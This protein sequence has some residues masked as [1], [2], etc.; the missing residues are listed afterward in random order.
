MRPVA[1]LG[2]LALAGLALAACGDDAAFCGDG[3]PDPGE[4]CDDGNEDQ[5]DFCRECRTFLPSTLT[6][7]WEFNRNESPPIFPGDSCIDMGVSSVAVEIVGPVTRS[8]SESCSL[9]QVVF[10]DLP[11]GSYVA[12]LTPR[13]SGEES[14]VAA[15]I[16]VTV[17]FTGQTLVHEVTVPYE[18]WTGDYTG[19]FYYR[20]LWGGADCSAA[21]PPVAEHRFLLEAGGGPVA[22]VT[23]DGD[24]LDGSATGPCRPFIEDFPQSAQSVPWGP[25]TFTITGYDSG[26]T[27]QFEESFDTFVGAGPNNPEYEFDVNSLTPDAGVPDAGAPDAGVPD[28]ASPDA[29][30]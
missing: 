10:S 5:T 25:A 15:P 6:I 23:D 21:A 17:P 29:G 28:A 4:E 8:E 19:T 11:A 9:R 18:A 26:G 24:A 16:E 12:R 13:D 20:V 30:V 27:A 22:V 1:G 2:A 7:K 14:R 3:Q